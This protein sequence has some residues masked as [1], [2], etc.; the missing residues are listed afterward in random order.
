MSPIDGMSS[1]VPEPPPRKKHKVSQEVQS[2]DNGKTL[3]QQV[4]AIVQSGDPKALPKA[5]DIALSH[6]DSNKI[7]E[8]VDEVVKSIDETSDQMFPDES[9]WDIRLEQFAQR[10]K[11]SQGARKQIAKEVIEQAIIEISDEIA[12]SNRVSEIGGT[13]ESIEQNAIRLSRIGEII[14]EKLEMLPPEVKQHFDEAASVVDVEQSWVGVGLDC[15]RM[16]IRE[17]KIEQ[18][19]NEQ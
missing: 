12:A 8:R 1:Q 4:S 19:S 15:Y 9:K 18:L 16:K 14:G 10:M 6:I 3:E 5:V 17:R 13:V 11:D 2:S 7:S